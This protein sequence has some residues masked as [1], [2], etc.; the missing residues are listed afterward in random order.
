MVSLERSNCSPACWSAVGGGLPGLGEPIR[1]WAARRGPLVSQPGL[2]RGNARD[3]G[4]QMKKG[5]A[6]SESPAWEWP[7]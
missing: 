3:I 2:L 5:K 7:Q 6:R 1:R 4:G